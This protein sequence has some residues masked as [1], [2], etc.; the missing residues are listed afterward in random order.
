ML[1]YL[2]S[3]PRPFG[4][5]PMPP[6]KRFNWEFY[7]VVAGTLA[8]SFND[9]RAPGPVAD[10]LWLFSPGCEHGWRSAPGQSCSVVVFHYSAVSPELQKLVARDGF[11]AVPLKAG[12]KREL[13]RLAATLA[14][15]VRQSSPLSDFYVERGL[16]DLSVIMLKRAGENATA[17]APSPSRAA[18][19]AATAA[20]SRSETRVL[21]AEQW[22]LSHLSQ[23]PTADDVARA[24]GVSTSH[25][26]RLFW[27]VRHRSPR[28]V[29]NRLRLEHAMQLLA[30]SDLK[31]AG[32]AS[33]SGFA[34]PSHFC[35]AFRKAFGT[36]PD[37]WRRFAYIQYEHPAARTMTAQ[38][39]G[40]HLRVLGP[41]E[42]EADV[43]SPK[44]TVLD[45]APANDDAAQHPAGRARRHA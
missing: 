35:Q 14:P 22:L 3:G 17:D 45:T 2:S 10:T 28:E 36:T 13:L 24:Q 44:I 19:P 27:A 25:L 30:Q 40:R 31:L 23:H 18:R 41:G 12:D 42:S 33:E 39:V 26:R 29:F 15:H 1:R 6:H 11:A 32:V 38:E 9:S 43:S 37:A 21:A 16:L 7:A 34:T 20:S 5:Y 8:P 4:D